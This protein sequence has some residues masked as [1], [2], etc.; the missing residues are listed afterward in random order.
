MKWYFSIKDSLLK[1]SFGL[2]VLSFLSF[3]VCCNFSIAATKVYPA[4]EGAKLSKI[5]L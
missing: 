3:M 4:P 5:I 2:K 1:F